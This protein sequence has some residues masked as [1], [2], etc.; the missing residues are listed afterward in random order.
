[1]SRRQPSKSKFSFGP[2]FGLRPQVQLE[3]SA[4]PRG[5]WALVSHVHGMC[6]MRSLVSSDP[7]R[8]TANLVSSNGLPHPLP[9]QTSLSRIRWRLIYFRDDER[10]LIPY[11]RCCD[12]GGPD[13]ATEPQRVVRIVER[14]LV[15]NGLDDTFR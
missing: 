2:S 15:V 7:K 8:T 14:F 12:I 9:C 6:S 3:G 11:G 4:S 5:T 13:D 10:G 1:M